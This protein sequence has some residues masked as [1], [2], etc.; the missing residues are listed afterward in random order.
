M[1][2]EKRHFLL[3]YVCLW[4]HIVIANCYYK[5]ERCHVK[6]AK[7][8]IF[9]TYIPSEIPQNGRKTAVTNFCKSSTTQRRVVRFCSNLIRTLTTWDPMYFKR[10]RS[11]GQ[12]SRLYCNAT[13]A[14][15]CEIINNWAAHVRFRSNLLQTLITW[16]TTN[17]QE[18][19]GQ[20]SRSQRDIT[21]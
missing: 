15:I 7:A 20:R 18:Q 4:N 3:F 2:L 17:V 8:A 5:V 10:S 16:Y 13:G 6:A 1:P 14:N 12:R 21:Y 19:G 11:R 9:K